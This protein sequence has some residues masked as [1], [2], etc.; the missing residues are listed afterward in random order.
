MDQLIQSAADAFGWR[1]PPDKLTDSVQIGAEDMADLVTFA[2]N[3]WAETTVVLWEQH[4]DVIH[5]FSPLA[6]CY[7]L[8]GVIKATVEANE[9]NL[10]VVGSVI[11]QLDR[12]PTPAWWDD[13]FLSRWPLLTAP[14]LDVMQAWIIWLTTCGH[15][16]FW[17]G[18]L[19]RAFD[20]LSLLQTRLKDASANSR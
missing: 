7:Y 2:R 15:N 13:H 4:F 5:Y 9:A 18:E 12:S 17:Q 6:F 8:P 1:S 11:G 10:V 19:D 3:S 20:T 14:E 16:P